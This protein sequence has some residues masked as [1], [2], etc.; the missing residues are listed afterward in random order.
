MRR[1]LASLLLLPALLPAAD[2]ARDIKPLLQERCYACHGAL[3]QKAGLR[4]DTVALMRQGG[5]AGDLLADNG[6]LLLE[7]VT[8]HDLDERMPPEGEGAALTQEQIDLLKAWISAGAPGPADEQPEPDPNSH[9]A[10]QRPEDRGATIDALLDQKLAARGLKAQPPAAPETWLRRVY[11]DLTGLP[12]SPQDSREFL[13]TQTP[14]TAPD[15]AATARAQVVDRLLAS[16][17]YGER[18]GRHFMDVWRYSDW[19][20]LGNQLRN[21]QKHL[22]HWRDWIVESLNTD[23]GY[24]TMI[25][26]MLA[27]DELAPEDRANL[28]ATGFLA[29]SYYLFNRTTWLDDTLE[30]TNR[31]FLGLTMQC[32]KC[33]DHKYD[34]IDHAEY[35]RMRAVFEPLHVRLD[36]QPGMTDLEKDGL[37]RV[38]D[39]HLDRPT[40][41][42]IRGDDKNEDLSRPLEPGVPKALKGATFA[43]QPVAL[44]PTSTR[45]LLLP[46]V[47]QDQL[48]TAEAEI[49]AAREQLAKLEASKPAAEA[50]DKSP[51]AAFPP[52]SDDFQTE[53]PDRYDRLAGD[54]HWS[55]GRL[56]QLE[57]GMKRRMIELRQPHPR[58]FTA[59]T[60]FTI[61]GGDKWKSVGLAFDGV[62]E[63]DTLVYASAVE[64]GSKVQVSLS[65]GGKA[66]YPAG[67][68]KALPIHTGQPYE[69]E[70][71]VRG[72]LL[73][74]RLD[75]QLIL[76]HRL[77]D[78]LASGRLRLAAFDAAADFHS[79]CV[80]TLAPDA[81]MESA[82][83]ELQLANQLQLARLRLA[84]AETR[85]AWLR[86]VHAAESRPE[87]NALAS[88]A[89]A[90]DAR[91]VLAQAEL[92]LFQAEHSAD[93]KDAKKK[94][95][96]E[97]KLKEA[98]T[99]LAEAR[100]KVQSPGNTYTLVRASLKAQEG[101]DEA[102]NT[103]VQR[104]PETST[105]RRLA[106]A[107]WIAAPDNPLTARVLVNHVWL[108]HFGAPLVADVSDFGRRS[109]TPLHQDV[110]DTL[111]V[112]FMK[113]DWSLK[114]LH[115][116]LVLSAAY[117]RLSSNAGAD[118][119]TLAADPD[120]LH[121]WRMNARRMESQTVRD[122]LL[123][124]SGRLDPSLGG[125]TLDPVKLETTARRSLYFNQ[126]ANEQNLFLGV[127]DNASVLECYRR[128]ESVAPQ[129]ALALVN[130]RLSH[131]C[132]T[133]LA[134][135]L[136][137]RDDRDFIREGFL[138]VLG[139]QA[140]AEETAACLASLA[141]LS[142]PLVLQALFNH[143]DFVTV[144]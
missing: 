102:G 72:D 138:A 62:G 88:S 78:R 140:S 22:W 120:N 31:A 80:A 26:Q 65:R 55:E 54:W 36:P 23:K 108:R 60:R 69:L 82:G 47:L 135:R 15:T 111:A 99:A 107:R 137:A 85:P 93:L 46:F 121:Y 48:R 74:V 17:Q 16:P 103:E 34:P 90:A 59:S 83:Q 39:L 141:Q 10:Y 84:L 49:Q 123:Q 20:G 144:R 27:A 134:E 2:Y 95:A 64:G 21:S 51:P 1:L 131:D 33:H 139:R 128:E 35:Y 79:L 98:R 68:A 37:P 118:P 12:P 119:A 45:P 143:N 57:T 43:V 71:R 52:L 28:R 92:D 40:W 24:D 25:L 11:L 86:A 67:A 117:A 3:K 9:W 106:L 91:R 42:H 66:S 18:W 5:D 113:N 58:D 13:A 61:T 30:H 126:T 75:G 110:L 7:R 127:F 89:A 41:R 115:R 133:A 94:A 70:L 50:P 14:A 77:S 87:D 129:Q 100:K 130:S 112:R 124:V 53:A 109:P 4:M 142:R 96:A 132:A 56:R 81:P 44:P 38:F 63:D 122:S 73:N 114:W 105:G 136:K 32:V 76:V 97:K 116:Q 8:S 125:P 104:F 6:A 19:Y 101:P 29:R